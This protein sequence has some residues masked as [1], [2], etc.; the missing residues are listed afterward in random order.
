MMG[1]LRTETKEVKKPHHLS[2]KSM[3]DILPPH[4]P[5]LR[6]QDLRWFSGFHMPIADRVSLVLAAGCS[7]DKDR[8]RE[9]IFM[10][11]VQ[12]QA[13]RLSHFPCLYT[14]FII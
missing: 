3:I 8:E 9:N 4:P 11:S 14:E 5:F 13:S 10:P 1:E 12:Q 7:A 6:A 2:S